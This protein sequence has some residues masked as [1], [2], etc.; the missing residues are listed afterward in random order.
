MGAVV[1]VYPTLRL[2]CAVNAHK[3]RASPTRRFHAYTPTPRLITC[4]RTGSQEPLQHGEPLFSTPASPFPS[5]SLC[6]TITRDIQSGEIIEHAGAVMV[7]GNVNSG[8][9]IH[10][11]G[12]IVVLGELEGEAHAGRNGDACAVIFAWSLKSKTLSIAG[13]DAGGPDCYSGH[14]CKVAYLS[15]GTVSVVDAGSKDFRFAPATSCRDF[16]PTRTTLS[17]ED[18]F[19]IDVM[20]MR[21]PSKVAA[22][23]GAYIFVVGVA[24]LLF[25]ESLFGLFFNLR[26]SVREWIR[27]GAVLAV[28]FGVYYIGTAWGDAKGYNGADAF[29]MSTIVGRM[30]IFL[31]FSWLVATGAGGLPLFIVGTVNLLGALTMLK[32]LRS[33]NMPQRSS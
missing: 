20:S 33:E 9:F 17:R 25:P 13:C 22:F 29:Y 19:A 2:A 21:K 11:S 18:K 15:N 7:K 1:A 27:V 8:A 12:D 31:S 3:P 5:S 6:L 10:A 24:V 28:V 30:F 23:T 32:A 26:S 4:C 16:V 14:I